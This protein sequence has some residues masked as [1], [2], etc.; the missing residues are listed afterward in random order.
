MALSAV[1]PSDSPASPASNVPAGTESAAPA[2]TTVDGPGG[3]QPGTE[4]SIAPE[5]EAPVAPDPN[6]TPP[7]TGSAQ[8]APQ[9]APSSETPRPAPTHD[10]NAVDPAL[11]PSHGTT[12]EGQAVPGVEFK[13]ADGSVVCGIARAGGPW[14]G[15]N[16]AM[17]DPSSWKTALHQYYSEEG[18]FAQSVVIADDASYPYGLEQLGLWWVHQA[19]TVPVLPDG[20]NITVGGITCSVADSA[21]TCVNSFK[22]GFV[23]TGTSFTEIR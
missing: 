13:T 16:Q 1:R 10:P 15:L 5:T 6:A 18:P 22:K 2:S 17:C 11:Y 3:V 14:G 12:R 21:V 4:A 9:P 20:K 7:A 23:L 8:P 19:D